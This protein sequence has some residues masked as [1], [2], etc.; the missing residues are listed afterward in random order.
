MQK[1]DDEAGCNLPQHSHKAAVRT[2][3]HLLS[4]P[5]LEVLLHVRQVLSVE[6]AEFTVKQRGFFPVIFKHSMTLCLQADVIRL[7]LDIWRLRV[8]RFCT[9]HDG[10]GFITH[11]VSS[12][13]LQHFVVFETLLAFI[14]LSFS[15]RCRRVALCL[16]RSWVTFIDLHRSLFALVGS[17]H[18]IN[19]GI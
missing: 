7:L 8:R 17:L 2:S 11:H 12:A 18:R 4:V 14:N 15:M 1:G 9:I 19:N 16:C 5:L 3:E 10:A 6:L 13:Y